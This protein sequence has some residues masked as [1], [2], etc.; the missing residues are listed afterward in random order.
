MIATQFSSPMKLQKAKKVKLS[1]FENESWL[2]AQIEQDPTILGLGDVVVLRR[3][4]RQSSGGKVDFLLHDPETDTMYEIEIMLGA[5][6][7]SHIIRTIEY[8]DIE[9][10]KNP[11]KE[12][13]A[14]IVAEELTSRFFNVIY[15]MNRAIPII[16]I[17][18]DA[19][20]VD[21]G[22]ILHFTKVLDIYETPEDTIALAAESTTRSYW[23]S[24]AN[25]DSMVS[26][27]AITDLCRQLYDQL[28]VTWN[29]YHIAIGTQRQNFCWLHPR[30]KQI[31]CHCNLSVGPGHAEKANAI[32]E[33]AG[34]PF[35]DRQ[36]GELALSLSAKEIELK[37]EPLKQLFE[38]AV[39]EYA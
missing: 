21:D 22:L 30:K 13:R 31:H 10:K 18:L 23:E 25:A 2:Q 3:E 4:R 6:D 32:L 19:L 1:D 36:S 11:S 38:L 27:D 17:Q 26:A 15:L 33:Q 16:A 12:H 39:Q 7:E 8:W 29:K 5:T 24:R 14:V 20:Q 9:S 34:I 28:K 37:K 35:T